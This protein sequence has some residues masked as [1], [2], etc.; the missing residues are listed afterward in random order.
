M[1]TADGEFGNAICKEHNCEQ[2][3]SLFQE[4]FYIQ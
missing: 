1:N 2:Q 3:S 4:I